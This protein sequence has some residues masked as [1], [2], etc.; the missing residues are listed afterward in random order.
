[1]KKHY[2]LTTSALKDY[3]FKQ[4]KIDGAKYPTEMFTEVVDR[5]KYICRT[6]T[7]D[8]IPC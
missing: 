5:E 2:H 1:M 4:Q 7:I 3:E 6:T 8:I